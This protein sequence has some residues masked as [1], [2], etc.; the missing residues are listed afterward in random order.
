MTTG[1]YRVNQSM[2]SDQKELGSH[3]GLHSK[4]CRCLK[5]RPAHCT[6]RL[7]LP[8]PNSAQTAQTIYRCIKLPTTIKFCSRSRRTNTLTR[9]PTTEAAAVQVATLQAAHTILQ[10]VHNSLTH[11]QYN[12]ATV[13]G[14]VLDTLTTLIQVIKFPNF[15][16]N[17][18]FI[19]AVIK[20]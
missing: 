13:C 9:P 19:T 12:Q 16:A 18:T 11:T 3:P 8:S 10:F 15:V 17:K 1:L 7:L 2:D 14:R 6:F 20:A 5:P 4:S